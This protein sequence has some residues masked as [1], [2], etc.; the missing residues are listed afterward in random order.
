MGVLTGIR[1]LDLATYIAAPAAATVMADFGAEVIKVERPPFGD[2][3]RYLSQVP[4]MP[5][6][7]EPYCWFLEGRNKKSLA[8]NL[9]RPQ[10][11]NVVERLVRW[12]DVLITNYQPQLQRKFRVRYE[13]IREWNPRM[14][15][16]SVTGYGEC[17]EESEK[18]GYDMTAYWARSG[19]MGLMHNANAD[20][21]LSVAGFGDHPTSMA[22]FGAIMMAL[23]RRERIGEGG[24]VS[25]TLMANGA[26]ANSSLLQAQFAGAHWMPRRDRIHPNNPFVN[27]YVTRDGQRFLF[28]M[29]EPERDWVRLCRAF[30][31]HDRVADERFTTPAGRRE[32]AAELVVMIDAEIARRD[33]AEWAAIFHAHE[34][35]WGPVPGMEQVASDPVM[36]AAGVFA[37]IEDTPYRTV[38]SP[39][40]LHGE[41]KTR[42]RPAPAVGEHSA[43]IL[44]LLGYTKEEAKQLQESGAVYGK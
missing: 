21:T 10:S 31:W 3:Y 33:M 27:H 9:E 26:W 28:C 36:E 14:I 8:L 37:P 43:E 25:T 40:N 12:C 29:L 6:S 44:Q 23:Y 16:A 34:I 13:D 20:P 18:P 39:I 38:M 42:P 22:L 11:R 7:P 19:L 4:G 24:K 1:V 41:E 35:I 2:P 15:Y 30:E 5:V 32:H 17:G